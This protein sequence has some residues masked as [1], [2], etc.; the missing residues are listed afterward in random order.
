MRIKT[1]TVSPQQI[2]VGDEL[3][4]NGEHV[5]TVTRIREGV[6]TINFKLLCKADG[7]VGQCTAQRDSSFERVISK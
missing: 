3:F 5:I 1:E 2:T 6:K 7:N 4:F